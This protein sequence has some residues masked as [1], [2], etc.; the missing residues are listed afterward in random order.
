MRNDNLVFQGAASIPDDILRMFGDPPLL[1]TEDPQLYSL[2]LCTIAQE[3]C[4]RNAIEWFWVKDIVD[5]TWEI[6]RLRR[7]RTVLIEIERQARF[8]P[9]PPP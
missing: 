9:P 7:F 3:V 4:P 6:Q 8:E 5:L 2:L 1:S